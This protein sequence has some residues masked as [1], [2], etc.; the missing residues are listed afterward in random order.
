MSCNECSDGRENSC[1]GHCF[2]LSK[3]VAGDAES[4][5]FKSRYGIHHFE[6]TSV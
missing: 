2:R 4:E 1:N 6:G 5:T 3:I